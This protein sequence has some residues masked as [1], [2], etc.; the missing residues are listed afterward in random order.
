MTLIKVAK[1]KILNS[2]DDLDYDMSPTP[3]QINEIYSNGFQGVIPDKAAYYSLRGQ[4]ERFY[5]AFPQ[6]IGVGKGKVSLPFKAVLSLEPEFGRY[7]A[8]TTGDCVS[9]NTRNAGMVDYCIDALFGETIYKGR[10]ATENIYGAR[11]HRGQGAN[12][13]TLANYVS[14]NGSGGFLVRGKYTSKDGKNSVDLS[15]YRSSIGASWGPMTPSWVNEIAS[16]NKALQVYAIKSM[17]EYRDAIATG[18][19]VS[20]CSGYGF[21]SSRNEDGLSEQRGSWSHAMAHIGC[22]DTDW[23]HQKYN[24]ML[25]LIQNSWGVFNSG[26]KRNDQP[27][28]SFWVRPQVVQKLINAG[29]CFC[30]ASVRGYNRELVYDT[31]ASVAKLSKD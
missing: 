17:E 29:G 11:G 8:Q 21:S 30:I 24:G 18:F 5:N 25:G 12:C 9:H 7:E 3:E 10:F 31:M 6:A 26:P 22:D 19:G 4:T 1:K 20:M 2:F 14:Q 23:A 16:E 15:V 27:D 13:S 28:G